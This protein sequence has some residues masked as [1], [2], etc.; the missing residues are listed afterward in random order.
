MF[1]QSLFVFNFDSSYSM[2]QSDGIS[3][4]RRRGAVLASIDKDQR[5]P[6]KTIS[7]TSEKQ[8]SKSSRPLQADASHLVLWGPKPGNIKKGQTKSPRENE[9]A[10]DSEFWGKFE[11][12]NVW[13]VSNVCTQMYVHV[14]HVFTGNS[15]SLRFN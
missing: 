10:K 7:Q 9:S 13:D 2:I 5:I 14:N 15:T 11:P 6:P 8:T 1:D 12:S 3:I 4:N